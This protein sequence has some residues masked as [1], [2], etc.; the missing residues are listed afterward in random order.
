MDGSITTISELERQ[1]PKNYQKPDAHIICM[2]HCMIFQLNIFNIDNKLH[3]KLGAEDKSNR[4][5]TIK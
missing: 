1:A 5:V 4:I 3:L 2:K